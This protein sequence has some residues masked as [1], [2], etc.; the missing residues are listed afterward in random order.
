V[1]FHVSFRRFGRVMSG[2]LMMPVGK[3]GMVASLLVIARVVVFGR[4]FMMAGG[5][6]MVFRCFSVVVGDML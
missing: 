2:M 4:M 3:M 6:F 5:V 1:V